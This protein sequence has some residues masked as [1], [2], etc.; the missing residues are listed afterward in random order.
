MDSLSSTSESPFLQF[1]ENTLLVFDKHVLPNLNAT[2]R[3]LFSRVSRVCRDA[4]NASDMPHAGVSCQLPFKVKDFVESVELLKWGK[5]NGCPL[6]DS[7]T[8]VL[9]A[10]SRNGSPEVMLYLQE[11]CCPWWGRASW[12][13]GKAPGHLPTAPQFRNLSYTVI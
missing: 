9:A 4:T 12:S 13:R 2:D 6:L 3:A 10:G 11:H 5:S 1:L 7:R 8:F